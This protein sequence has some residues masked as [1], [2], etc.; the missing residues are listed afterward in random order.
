MEF[1]QE[2]KIEGFPKNGNYEDLHSSSLPPRL[3]RLAKLPWEST[4]I[5]QLRTEGK[6]GNT[7]KSYLC[8][9][10]KFIKISLPDE[11]DFESES[12]SNMPLI[13][14]SE[15]I[16][17]DNGRLDIWL[18]SMHN[19]KNSTINARIA[20]AS[21]LIIWVGHSIPEYLSRPNKGKHIPRTLTASELK[22]V[23]DAAYNSENPMMHLIVTIFLDTGIRVSEL[24]SLD[25][26]DIDLQDKSARVVGGKGNKDRLVLFTNDSV[27]AIQKWISLREKRIRDDNLALFINQHG[28]RITP[29]SIQK[30]MDKLADDASIPRTRLSPHVLRHNFATGLLERGADLVSIQRL[31]GHSS[32]ATT[33]IYLEISDQ[34][35][36]EVYQRAQSNRNLLEDEVKTNE[37]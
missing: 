16:N 10:K 25:F 4:W 31:L 23:R 26:H 7:I 20:A 11:I 35:L 27:V 36:R 34:T 15:R 22:K 18:Q 17:P 14:L 37:N 8:A 3:H 32:I 33:R 6:S 29:R 1:E 2:A 19:L 28:N 30:L 21:H 9:V 13:S 24:C 12:I 5:Q